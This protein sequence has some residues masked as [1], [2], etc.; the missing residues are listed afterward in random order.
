MQHTESQ[1]THCIATCGAM[2]AESS[3]REG[4]QRTYDMHNMLS[5]RGWS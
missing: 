5:S 1:L 2:V 4:G 3:Y